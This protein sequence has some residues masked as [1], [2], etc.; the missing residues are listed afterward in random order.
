MEDLVDGGCAP[1]GVL[2]QATDNVLINVH[3]LPASITRA[4]ALMRAASRDG[5][6][7]LWPAAPRA[8]AHSW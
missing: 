2:D 5:A 3:V 8:A 7:G 1:T 6:A 4:P